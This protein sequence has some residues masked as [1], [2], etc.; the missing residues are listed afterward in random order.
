M[1]EDREPFRHTKLGRFTHFVGALLF[2]L[3]V[4]AVISVLL[5]WM[6]LTKQ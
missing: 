1:K 5:Y 2:M 4:L 3:L 6:Y